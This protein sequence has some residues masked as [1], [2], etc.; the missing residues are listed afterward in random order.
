MR[1]NNN[2]SIFSLYWS[3]GYYITVILNKLMYVFLIILSIILL[4]SSSVNGTFST[5]INNIIKVPLTPYIY[6][7]KLT[8]NIANFIKLNFDSFINLKTKYENLKK[9]NLDLKIKL[10][11]TNNVNEENNSLKRILN[12]IL[13]ESRENYTI[14]QINIIN[15]GVFNTTIDIDINNVD[16]NNIS[17]HD[18]VVDCDGNFVGI[19]TDI[20]EKNATIMLATDYI[21]KIPAKTIESNTSLILSGSGNNMLEIEHF[22]GKKENISNGDKVYTSNDGSIFFDWIYIGDI[23]SI[24]DKIYVK[25]AT[26]LNNLSYVIILHKEVV[27]NIL[28]QYETF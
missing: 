8:I 5:T 15:K 3:V 11:R 1:F 27:K 23:V 20:K 13:N 12:F 6:L 18:I 9:V 4:R 22:L 19:V 14:K 24:N 21:S 17:E 10:L 7:E 26:N 28:E 2:N 16:R 25:L